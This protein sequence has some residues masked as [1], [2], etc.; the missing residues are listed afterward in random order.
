M[1]RKVKTALVIFTIKQLRKLLVILNRAEIRHDKESREII[2]HLQDTLYD[3]TG[4]WWV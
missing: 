4:S 3:F 1:I 2:K